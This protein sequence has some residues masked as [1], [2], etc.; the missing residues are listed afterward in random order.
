M[1]MPRSGAKMMEMC[2]KVPEQIFFHTLCV[3]SFQHAWLNCLQTK[4]AGIA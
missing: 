4:T 1:T 3:V 2:E